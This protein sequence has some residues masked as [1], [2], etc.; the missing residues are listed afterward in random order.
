MNLLRRLQP[1]DVERL[2]GAGTTPDDATIASARAIVDDVVRR[3]EAAVRDHAGRF[4]DLAP[5]APL[6]HDAKAL[7]AAF[8]ALPPLD[9]DLLLRT[10]AR[11]AAFA[12][13]Q[14]ESL[15]E[16]A[17]EVPGGTVLQRIA[18]VGRAGCYAPGGRFPLPSSVLMT[19]CT[20]RAAGVND[21]TVA[22]PRPTPLVLAAAHAAGA[23]RLLAVG[24]VQAIAALARGLDGLLP[25]DVI[26][27]P[28]NR[29]V[30]AAKLCVQGRVGIDL[31]A[32]P[33]ELV[34]L[35]D[36]SADPALV[37]ADL[38]AQAEHDED[39][40]PFVVLAGAAL[41][42]PAIERELAAQLAVLPTAATARAALAQGGAI[43]CRDLDEAIAVCDALAPEHLQ[44]A[45][46]P[47]AEASA[48]LRLR[49]YGA[50]FSGRHGAEVF[51]DYGIG[52]N[53]V[54]PTAG[55]AR[56]SGGLSVFAFLRVR[57]ELRLDAVDAGIA[58]DAAALAAHEGLAAHAAAARRRLS[59]PAS[60][61]PD[62]ASPCRRS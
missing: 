34:V 32:G 30:T 21:V 40:R 25:C 49:H 23:D 4:G 47:A 46:D 14:R 26:V 28:G 33:S 15:R 48:R 3:G 27:G 58:R 44:L 13:A 7:A 17:F 38:L 41:L 52:P 31:P 60:A 24:G 39:A 35:G 57:T 19:A 36:R 9:R 54:L 45:L 29:F 1:G 6:V 61:D 10:A 12:H 8:A 37:A 11:I 53:H 5:G 16:F 62:P 55:A 42:L 56:W 20:A 59:C 18:P 50:L 51:G 43:V 22:S 2:G